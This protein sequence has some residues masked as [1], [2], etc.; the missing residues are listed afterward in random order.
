LDLDWDVLL[1]LHKNDVEDMWNIM[2]ER[3][4]LERVVKYVP[5]NLPFSSWKNSMETTY[6][7][8]HL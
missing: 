4:I 3:K 6:K 2:K 7:C 5:S 1:S 8:Q